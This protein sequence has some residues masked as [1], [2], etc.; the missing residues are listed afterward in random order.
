MIGLSIFEWLIRAVGIALSLFTS[1]GSVEGH[2][3]ADAV[4]GEGA[5]AARWEAASGGEGRHMQFS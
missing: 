1:C 3:H 4:R 5:D 2:A